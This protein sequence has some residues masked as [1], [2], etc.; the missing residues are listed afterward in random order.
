QAFERQVD[1]AIARHFRQ[2][3]GVEISDDERRAD[4][5]NALRLYYTVQANRRLLRKLL[6]HESLGDRS[7]MR[8]HSANAAFLRALQ[9]R[10]VNVD[11]WLGGWALEE[12]VG[13]DTW[14]IALE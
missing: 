12:L 10:G 3:V 14:R 13:R 8:R 9:A 2:V 1:A 6:V 5:D 11:A 7:W 4:W